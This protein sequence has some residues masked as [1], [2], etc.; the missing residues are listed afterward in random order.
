[1]NTSTLDVPGLI[2]AIRH[3]AELHNSYD[4]F[5]EEKAIEALQAG[6]PVFWS[7]AQYSNQAAMI[8]HTRANCDGLAAALAEHPH[9]AEW[10][11]TLIPLTPSAEVALEEAR[12]QIA[13]AL[14]GKQE[15]A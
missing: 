11:E 9:F 15:A 8:L 13:G 10:I 3:H 4:T 6:R 7:S 2:R 12:W 14:Q 5:Q 1:M